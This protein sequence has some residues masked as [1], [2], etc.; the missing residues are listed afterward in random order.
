MYGDLDASVSGTAYYT[1]GSFSHH[2]PFI[3]SGYGFDIVLDGI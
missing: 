2:G 1:G 3:R